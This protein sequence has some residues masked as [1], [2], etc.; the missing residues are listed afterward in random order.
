MACIS[1]YNHIFLFYVITFILTDSYSA[2]LTLQLRHRRV[3]TFHVF[4]DIYLS[5]HA[6]N[7]LVVELLSVSMRFLW[8]MWCQW[9]HMQGYAEYIL[10]WHYFGSVDY[11]VLHYT[12]KIALLIDNPKQEFIHHKNQFTFCDVCEFL[13]LTIQSHHRLWLDVNYG[14]LCNF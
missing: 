7:S 11:M 6:L 3:I 4:V 5:I 10:W 1:N 8:H 9:M 2:E 12:H 13:F 14:R